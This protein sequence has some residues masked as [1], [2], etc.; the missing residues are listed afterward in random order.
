MA[1]L[2]PALTI[3]ISCGW[4]GLVEP[5]ETRYAEIGREMLAGG[6]WVVPHLN[7]IPHFH[8]PPV[9]YW[10]VASGMALLGVNEWGARLGMALAAGFVL[11]CATRIARSTGTDPRLTPVL[12]ISSILFFVLSHQLGSD[13]FLA[14]SVAG[15]YAAYFDFRG[16]NTLWPFVSIG[17]G[18][19]AKGPVVLVL[20]VAPV[21]FAA[22]WL[23]DRSGAR[24]LANGRG[25]LLLAV[26]ALPWYLALVMET[27]GLLTYFLRD[28]LWQR[29]TTTVHQRGGPIYYFVP[30]VVAGA[31]PWTWAAL[32]EGWGA[33]RQRW[34]A[35]RGGAEGNPSFEKTLLA[36]WILVPVLFFSFSGSK[37]P[38]Y[39]LP[40]FPAIAVLAA[41]G[42][43]RGSGGAVGDTTITLFA[44]AA[45]VEVLAYLLSHGTRQPG[46]FWAT[47]HTATFALAAAAV[48]IHRGRPLR[49]GSLVLV[50]LFILLWAAVP[51]EAEI[52]SP[53]P[54]VRVLKESRRPGEPVIEF[55]SFNAGVPFYLGETVP[56][57]DVPRDLGFEPPSV[58][59]RAFLRRADVPRRV[60]SRGRAWVTGNM[61]DIDRLAKALGLRVSYV[62]GS[63]DRSLVL[64]EARR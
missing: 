52:G 34:A 23:R 63:G 4:L 17:V 6:D 45:G 29:Y 11:W 19:M 24:P 2:F 26:V 62:A 30:V 46:T 35:V 1:W 43:S 60:E 47:A 49:A 61:E 7:G 10:A 64:L 51:F 37:L 22:W 32:R 57:L 33:V 36:A 39:V 16:R 44:L 28:Q 40:V 15:F 42:L 53:R 38:A 9:A 25:W 56:M 18:F 31:L 14:A 41:R 13:M 5:T 50:G 12:L 3:L 54:L 27:P 48:D 8:K 59:S 21:L 58:R 55:G 20:T